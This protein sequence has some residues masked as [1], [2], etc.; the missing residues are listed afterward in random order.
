MINHLKTLTGEEIPNDFSLPKVKGKFKGEHIPEFNCDT[1]GV[2]FLGNTKGTSDMEN[3]D[4]FHEDIEEKEEFS[5]QP[6]AVVKTRDFTNNSKVF[7]NVCV[8]SLE[9]HYM[10]IGEGC[11]R[12]IDDKNG[13]T[14]TTYDVCVNGKMLESPEDQ[15]KVILLCVYILAN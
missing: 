11:P 6:F 10:V 13:S 4:L 3:S 7:I 14:S 1:K 8:G 15:K 9:S 12:L 2:V 5:G